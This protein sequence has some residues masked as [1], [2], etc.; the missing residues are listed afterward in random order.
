MITTV[1]LNASVDK[2]YVM[3][4]EI[5]GGTVMRVQ[6]CR[7]SAGG[8]GLNVS[9]VIDLCGADVKA[10]GL[11]GGYNGSYLE[12]LLEEDGIRNEFCHIAGET[13]SC[14]NILDPKFSST[15]FL[16]PGCEV[17]GEE[18]DTFFARFP[19]IIADSSVVT[20]SGSIPKGVPTDVYAKLVSIA[21]E[22]GKQVLLDTSGEPLTR[23]MEAVPTLVKPNKDELEDLFSVKVRSIEDVL[24]CAEKLADTG[25]EYV[26]V[27]M[28]GD[29]ALM[30]C[31]DGVFR[32]VSPDVDVVNTVGCGDSMI[33]GFAVAFER[34]LSPADALRYASSVA[35]ANALSPNTGDFDPAVQNEL[36][37]RTAVQKLA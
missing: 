9:R 19:E 11:A 8:K 27:S 6:K 24:A 34:G 15:E 25:I 4:K 10:T 14:I 5:V 28:G 22:N 37:E 2:A 18:L 30:L 33:G 3:E 21:R 36:Y 7:N 13:R 23:G 31:K 16:E 32:A 12:K 17:T 1:T 29:G 35:T 20:L 26:V